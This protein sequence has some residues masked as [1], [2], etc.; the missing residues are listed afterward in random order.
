[1]FYSGA[2]ED[3]FDSNSKSKWLTAEELVEL[4]Q[5]SKEVNNTRMF[6]VQYRPVVE[7]ADP[8]DI[9]PVSVLNAKIIDYLDFSFVPSH[10]ANRILTALNKHVIARRDKGNNTFDPTDPADIE[11]LR[12]GSKVF[13]M[14]RTW[15]EGIS[16]ISKPILYIGELIMKSRENLLTVNGL[17]PKSVDTIE[18]AL[19][20]RGLRLGMAIPKNWTSPPSQ[21]IPLEVLNERIFEYLDFSFTTTRTVKKI[22]QAFRFAEIIEDDIGYRY[23]ERGIWAD[24][25]PPSG[26]KY[27]AELVQL[28]KNDWSKLRLGK[29]AIAVI[30]Q[31]LR[32]RG[33]RLEM[34]VSEEW[35]RPTI[36]MPMEVLNARVVDY[37]ELNVA[38]NNATEENTLHLDTRVNSQVVQQL[39]KNLIV[40]VGE[41]IQKSREEL[42]ILGLDSRSLSALEKALGKKDLHLDTNLSKE[43]TPPVIHTEQVLNEKILDYLDFSFASSNARRQLLRKLKV[44]QIVY[45][46]DLI[47]FISSWNDAAF[48]LGVASYFWSRFYKVLDKL[49]RKYRFTQNQVSLIRQALAQADLLNIKLPKEWVIPDAKQVE[50]E[51]LDAK[52]NDYL[53]FNS[54]ATPVSHSTRENILHFDSVVRALINTSLTERKITYIGELIQLSREDLLTVFKMDPNHVSIIE[55]ILAEKGLHLSTKL[56]TVWTHPVLI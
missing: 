20:Q 46:G 23:V 9:V 14:E 40:Y 38:K 31:A 41:L 3:V 7:K 33:L 16:Y 42:A 32:Q 2:C 1:M 13:D 22:A 34:R 15:D 36:D 50:R 17:G 27:I 25:K 10:S 37:L 48:R 6:Q 24:D 12:T 43:W 29:T 30:E 53:G 11:S 54:S 28:D 35:T 55:A 26:I 39:R 56:S 19:A 44:N 21:E 47:L 5:S 51:I 52:V 45:I 49:D 4:V 18:Q 8:T